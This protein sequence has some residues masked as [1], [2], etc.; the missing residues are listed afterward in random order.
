MAHERGREAAK[1]YSYKIQTYKTEIYIEGNINMI[2]EVE[3]I[4]KD[5]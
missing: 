5:L 4:K 3:K 1:G 2:M